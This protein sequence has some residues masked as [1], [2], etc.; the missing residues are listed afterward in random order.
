MTNRQYAVYAARNKIGYSQNLGETPVA[1]V[2]WL[3]AIKHLNWLSTQMEKSHITNLETVPCNQTPKNHCSK[4]SKKSDGY[5]LPTETEWE[6]AAR[7]GQN[8]EQNDT[9]KQKSI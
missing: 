2:S 8:L 5:R 4:Y 6:Y 7:G 1:E 9:R 3:D